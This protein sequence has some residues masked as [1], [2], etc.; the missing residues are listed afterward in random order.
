MKNDMFSQMIRKVL[1]KKH[2]AKP[3]GWNQGFSE[4]IRKMMEADTIEEGYRAIHPYEKA[5]FKNFSGDLN[6]NEYNRT[7][8]DLVMFWKCLLKI[9]HNKELPNLIQ[10]KYLEYISAI[11][12]KEE[13]LIFFVKVEQHND[14]SYD[15]EKFSFY[16]QYLELLSESL[17]ML[18][19]EHLVTTSDNISFIV[20]FGA[21]VSVALFVHLRSAKEQIEGV[22][23]S[24]SHSFSRSR[25]S[26]SFV[27][28]TGVFDKTKTFCVSTHFF[29]LVRGTGSSH[30]HQRLEKVNEE[31][32]S[33]MKTEQSYIPFWIRTKRT[34][35]IL[36]FEC[37]F[38]HILLVHKSSK[39]GSFKISSIPG[40]DILIEILF[41]FIESFVHYNS[42]AQRAES[43]ARGFVNNYSTS[44]VVE[45][46]WR[47]AIS[48]DYKVIDLSFQLGL[49]HLKLI[50]TS[51]EATEQADDVNAEYFSQMF[52]VLLS[53]DHYEVV[54]RCC[55][56]LFEV[57]PLMVGNFRK[58]F[59]L[60]L[61]NKSFAKV[62]FHW[63]EEVRIYFQVVLVYK[64]FLCPRSSLDIKS[65]ARLRKCEN[66]FKIDSPYK[67]QP[68]KPSSAGKNVSKQNSIFKHLIPGKDAKLHFRSLVE[69]KKANVHQGGLQCL[70]ADALVLAKF[71]AI[72]LMLLDEPEKIPKECKVYKDSAFSSLC[73]VLNLYYSSPATREYSGIIKITTEL[74]GVH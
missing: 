12:S 20:R 24:S 55:T 54:L 29:S 6:L 36:F 18:S 50:F 33:Y 17:K 35:F 56:F 31:V 22:L 65:D 68:L 26:G 14:E 47:K 2:T 42:I 41:T 15:H 27:K 3:A 49:V 51:M 73:K 60:D 62:F 1:P 8:V 61:L 28:P 67:I 34:F 64:L 40:Y 19:P 52:S 23:R 10:K 16:L 74:D 58:T 53:N 25:I 45:R 72:V 69:T 71:D 38:D 48:E 46:V 30:Q 63:S 32:T 7:L 43:G 9:L 4:A 37:F 5:I 59:L 70:Q 57:L 13:F 21:Q 44:A 11:L 39:V 66:S